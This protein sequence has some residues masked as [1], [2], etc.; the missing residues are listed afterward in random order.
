MRIFPCAEVRGD[1]FGNP[2]EKRDEEEGDSHGHASNARC[3]REFHPHAPKDKEDEWNED[4]S[5][6]RK[7]VIREKIDVD[8]DGEG[9]GGGVAN[10][11]GKSN[12]HDTPGLA[13]VASH[14]RIHKAAVQRNGGD[15]KNAFFRI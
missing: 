13:D 12:L 11:A 9:C 3:D 1:V 8:D 10:G 15:F 4:P 5:Y 14:G 7:I 2:D 6:V